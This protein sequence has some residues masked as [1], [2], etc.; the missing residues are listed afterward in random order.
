[1]NNQVTLV[2][3]FPIRPDSIPRLYGYRLELGK[4]NEFLIGGKLSYRIRNE[5]P[6]HW[7]WTDEHLVTDTFQKSELISHFI[8]KL[9]EKFPKDFAQLQ[10]VIYDEAWAP[11]LQAQADFIARCMFADIENDIR[12]KLSSEKFDEALIQRHHELRGWVVQNIPAVS[13]SI[14][15]HLVYK[16]DLASYYNSDKNQDILHLL[17]A[18]KTSSFKGE[19]IEIVGPLSEHRKRLLKLTQ[20]AEMQKIIE[21]APNDELIVKVDG[22]REQYDYPTSALQIILRIQDMKRFKINSQNMSQALRIKPSLR[23]DLIKKISHVAKTKNLIDDPFNSKDYPNFFLK[24]NDIQY[25]PQLTFGR[26][27]I[28]YNQKNLLTNLKKLGIYKRSNKFDKDAIK[29]GIINSIEEKDILSFKKELEKELQHLNFNI[30]YVSEEKINSPHRYELENALNKLLLYNPNLILIFLPDEDLE[31]DLSSY[32]HIKSLTIAQDIASQVV[33]KS[34]LKKTSSAL[35]NIVLGILSKVGNIP[36]ILGQPLSYADL[37]VG[38]DIAREK[39]KRLSGSINATATARIYFNNGEFLR[40]VIHDAPLEGETIPKH[41]LQ[42]LFPVNEFKG[43]RVIIHRDGFFRG[44]EKHV[45]KEW[46]KQISSTFHLVEIIKTGVPR[47][48]LWDKQ[49]TLQPPKGSAFVLNDNEAFLISTLP[50]FKNATPQP[51]RVRCESDFSIKEALHSVLSLT[52]LHY[53]SVFPPR[54]PVTIHYSDQLAAL[55][56]KGIKPK[57]LVGDIPYWL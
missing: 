17:V 49:S 45:L 34:T 32:F 6:G 9:W 21:K 24:T 44:E 31:E 3:L 33:Y 46:A 11:S 2:E 41:V 19:V 16:K 26:G 18:D 23:A 40:Y 35:A 4:S 56:V 12:K 53:G 7:V 39:K 54:L 47:L 1:M 52:L 14:F 25:Q 13:I 10:K 20:R 43:K 27:T 22:L 42:S 51:L 30:A 29:I 15:S 36:F 50:P 57:N 55:A 8:E 28:N 37:V 48:Y 38:I 5:F